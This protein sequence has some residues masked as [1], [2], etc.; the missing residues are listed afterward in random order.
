MAATRL[1]PA[2]GFGQARNREQA[3]SHRLRARNRARALCG[4]QPW[5]PTGPEPRAAYNPPSPS[6]SEDPSHRNR[7][8]PRVVRISCGSGPGY[9]RGLSRAPRTAHRRCRGQKTPPTEA[10]LRPHLGRDPCGSGLGRDAALAGRRHRSRR[11]SC[12]QARPHRRPTAQREPL[13]CRCLEVV[14]TQH[15]K[16]VRNDRPTRVSGLSDRTTVASYDAVRIPSVRCP[17]ACCHPTGEE[18]YPFMN[19]SLARLPCAGIRTGTV[20]APGGLFDRGQIDQ[21]TPA[22]GGRRRRAVGLFKWRRGDDDR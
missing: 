1:W 15:V 22:H 4:K 5:L 18:N 9:R 8:R 12:E 19:Q 17:S 6:G 20:L 3:R 10:R 14:A 11:Q 13:R 21:E 7:L 2:A 16:T